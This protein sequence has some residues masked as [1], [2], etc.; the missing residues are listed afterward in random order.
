MLLFRETNGR[1]AGR[2]AAEHTCPVRRF[3]VAAL[4]EQ[5][6]QQPG[7][8]PSYLLTGWLIPGAHINMDLSCHLPGSSKQAGKVDDRAVMPLKIISSA[9]ASSFYSVHIFSSPLSVYFPLFSRSTVPT[10]ELEF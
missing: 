6:G 4:A 9:L 1:S 7:A 10:S 5:D 3:C 8:P 2:T